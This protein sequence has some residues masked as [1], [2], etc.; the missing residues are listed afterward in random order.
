MD[1]DDKMEV[2]KSRSKKVTKKN[3]VYNRPST[4]QNLAGKK[5]SRV[6]RKFRPTLK[7]KNEEDYAKCQT[8]KVN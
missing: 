2:G 3:D 7:E 1:F 6:E 8:E 4:K 5:T